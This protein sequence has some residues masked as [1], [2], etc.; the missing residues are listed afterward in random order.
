MTETA[1]LTGWGRTA[2][3]RAEIVRPGG[4]EE[5]VAALAN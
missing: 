2:P 3:T 4:V 5:V 1:L